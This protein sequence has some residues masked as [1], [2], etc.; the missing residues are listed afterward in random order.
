[1]TA[2]CWI[3]RKT[4][5]MSMPK[6]KDALPPEGGDGGGILDYVAAALEEAG[7]CPSSF[8]V[9]PEWVKEK[10]L[11]MQRLERQTKVKVR[12]YP[13]PTKETLSFHAE[14]E[15]P[16]DYRLNEIIRLMEL[17]STP[18]GL[19]RGRGIEGAVKD[20]AAVVKAA[21]IEILHEAPPRIPNMGRM[22]LSFT[23]ERSK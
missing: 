13:K 3:P 4:A 9:E 20:G 23:M 16:P 18:D 6:I 11:P 21:Y 5:Y 19:V 12:W 7:F 8:F 2:M 22:E 15:T 17:V 1:M 10:R 14:E